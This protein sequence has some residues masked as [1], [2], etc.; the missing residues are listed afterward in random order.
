MVT[1]L[2]RKLKE[3]THAWKASDRYVAG[4]PDIVGC[5][6]GRF[7]AIEAKIDYNHASAIQV[8]TMLSIAKHGGYVGVVTYN[9]RKKQWWVL[10]KSYTI[11]EVVAYIIGKIEAGGNDIENEIV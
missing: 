7:F 8:H 4:I 11:G 5:H 1:S 9:N 3:R 6:K 2:L 10:G